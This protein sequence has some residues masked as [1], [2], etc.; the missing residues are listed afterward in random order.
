LKEQINFE[1]I[2]LSALNWQKSI[3]EKSS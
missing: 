3:Q 1:T 2:L